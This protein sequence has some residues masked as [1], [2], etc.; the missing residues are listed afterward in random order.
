M[1]EE[2]DKYRRGRGTPQRNGRQA[3][4]LEDKVG[5]RRGRP[6][7]MPRNG[8][9]R[10]FS[11]AVIFGTLPRCSLNQKVGSTMYTHCT[12]RQKY[13]KGSDRRSAVDLARPRR[14]VS[15]FCTAG[16]QARR[17]WRREVS[18]CCR[19]LMRFEFIPSYGTA[20]DGNDRKEGKRPREEGRGA[21]LGRPSTIARM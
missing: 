1:P 8:V 12:E 13:A 21:R 10:S 16:Q 17:G 14:R 20:R 19:D 15:R 4:K 3:P 9:S 5:P 18:R 6:A 7:A 11:P 2:V